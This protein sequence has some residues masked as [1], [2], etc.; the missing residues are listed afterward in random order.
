MA[1]VLGCGCPTTPGRTV[2]DP[3]RHTA[4]H[5][6][7]ETQGGPAGAVDHVTLCAARGFATPTL[8]SET[9][10]DRRA[11]ESGRRVS[12]ARRRAARGEVA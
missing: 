5:A 9:V 2:T 11:V 3:E 8:M 10:L 7:V 6:L 1:D 12:G 4:W